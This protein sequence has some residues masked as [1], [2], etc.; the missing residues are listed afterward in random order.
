MTTAP[1]PGPPVA[2]GPPPQPDLSHLT[3][4]ERRI[5]ESVM[6][7]QKEEEDREKEILRS[8]L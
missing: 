4:E 1:K 6:A 7:R 5:I 8:E 3:E 2:T